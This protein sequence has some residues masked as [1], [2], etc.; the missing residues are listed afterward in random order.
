MF[1]DEA[2]QARCSSKSGVDNS[3][4]NKECKKASL[5]LEKK[6][7]TITCIINQRFWVCNRQGV[8]NTQQ[9]NRLESFLYKVLLFLISDTEKKRATS[10]QSN[11]LKPTIIFTL[12]MS[13]TCVLFTDGCEMSN[14]FRAMIIIIIITGVCFHSTESLSHYS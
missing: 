2:K 8:Q 10:C 5:Y 9:Y 6:T 4:T 13:C 14:T 3:F 1:K 11:H 7:H 12:L